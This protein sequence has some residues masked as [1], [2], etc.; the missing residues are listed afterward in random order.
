MYKHVQL[1][2]PFMSSKKQTVLH[3]VRLPSFFTRYNSTSYIVFSAS[4][5]IKHKLDFKIVVLNQFDL[6]FIID[7]YMYNFFFQAVQE[8]TDLCKSSTIDAVESALPFWPRLFNK[9]AMVRSD[10]T[11][12]RSD[13]VFILA[14]RLHNKCT[15]R[16]LPLLIHAM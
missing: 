12:S 10:D 11:Q 9:L 2:W 1:Q 7:R 14:C 5:C 8:F 13:S 6:G 3:T 16:L 15:C 4:F